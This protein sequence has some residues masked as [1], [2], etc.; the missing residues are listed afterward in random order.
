[1]NKPNRRPRRALSAASFAAAAVAAALLAVPASAAAQTGEADC[2]SLGDH[3]MAA[4]LESALDLAAACG[5]EVRIEGRSGPYATTAATPDGRLHYTGTTAPAQ[6]YEDRGLADPTLTEDAGTLAQANTPWPITLS[7]TDTGAPLIQTNGTA[8][9]WTGEKPVPSYDGTT[10]VY[11]DL[12]AGLDLTVGSGIAATDLTFT[13]ADPDAWNALATGLVFQADPAVRK[14]RSMLYTSA[15]TG[16]A[17]YSESFTVRDAAGSVVLP[18]LTIT[19]GALTMELPTE[20]A[21]AAVYPLTLTTAWSYLG[22][23]VATWQSITS[24]SPDLSVVRGDG[25]LDLP[26]FEAAGETG[27]ALS[28]AYCDRLLDPEC[29]T[30]SQST[31]YWLFWNPGP[32]GLRPDEAPWLTFPLESAVFQVGAAAGTT[33]VA[34]DV[35]YGTSG[36]LPSTDWN[37]PVNLAG[38]R[39]ATGACDD[40]TAVYDLTSALKDSWKSNVP[41]SMPGGDTT[42]RF[43]GGTAR[44][45]AYFQVRTYTVASA[46]PA[47]YAEPVE[48]PEVRYGVFAA[49]F[50]RPDLIDPGLTWTTKVYNVANDTVIARTESAPVTDGGGAGAVVEDVPD[51]YYIEDLRISAS[52]GTTVKVIQCSTLVDTAAP[53]IE[54]TAPDGPNYVGDEIE[55][56]VHVDDGSWSDMY[57]TCRNYPGCDPGGAA[58]F[59]ERDAVFGIRLNMTDNSVDIEAEDPAGRV[60]RQQIDIPATRNRFDYDGDRNQDLIAVRSADGALMLYSGRGDG[61]FAPGVPIATGWGGMDLAMAGDLTSDGNADLLA[62]DRAT[63]VMYTY[64]G[65]GRGGFTAAPVRVGSG[66]NAMGTFTSAGDF[67]TDGTIDLLAVDRSD[68]TLYRYPGNGDGTFGARVASGT[69]WDVAESLISIG[70]QNKDGADDL[71]ARE[72]HNGGYLLYTG[73]G[74]GAFTRYRSL[75]PGM[76]SP[77]PAALYDQIA[78]GGDYNGDGYVDVL[79]T[80]SRTGELTLRTFDYQIRAL[81]EFQVVGT[82]WNALRLPSA[83]ITTA[84]DHNYDG[85][86]DLFARAASTG[87]RY[88]YEGDGEGGFTGRAL[89]SQ[90]GDLNLI[91]TAGDFDADGSSDLLV[92][93]AATGRLY[94]VPGVNGNVHPYGTELLVGTG[95]NKMSAIVSGH[96]FDGDG[97]VDILAREASTGYLWLYPGGGD[98]TGGARVKAGSGWNSM[99]ELTAVGDLDHDGHADLLAIRTSDNCLYRYGGNGDGTLKAAVKVGCGWSGLDALAAVGDFSGDGHA[100]FVARRKSDGALF[101]YKGDGTGDFPSAATV[102]TGW[103]AMDIIV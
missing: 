98:G 32:A 34:P 76:Y 46:C 72:L 65:T 61:T 2:G 79:A 51:G 26:Y 37:H 67:D 41:L 36:L 75:L 95:W 35:L 38:A 42:A 23:E 80:D 81:D 15:G 21:E 43:D 62:L 83:S 69:G 94:F 78:G 29:L 20:A 10:A 84:Y 93:E 63:G 13:V 8:I 92:R 87:T 25:G 18:A 4:G 49:D 66:W 100:D 39:A 90:D 17:E 22:T 56:A 99:R 7:H 52:D 6:Q 1:M 101:L 64:A 89:W 70:D 74:N 88:L 97:D 86:P 5:V 77:D 85:T 24:A 50:W 9:D 3:P 45:D 71:L 53:S 40:G 27:D 68:G 103:N 59:E 102:G 33:C 28:G 30:P 55:L 60:T 11:D 58:L 91:E 31:S 82:G 14:N 48:T 44:L 19:G 57:L 12:A 73:D 47:S 16:T 54:I 96:D